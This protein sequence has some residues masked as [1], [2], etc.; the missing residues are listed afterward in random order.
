M[1]RHKNHKLL[2]EEPV[3]IDVGD[4]VV[5]L[6]PKEN[7][8]A[9]PR[10]KF[11]EC[12]RLME[13]PKDFDAVPGLILGYNQAERALFDKHLEQVV[14]KLAFGGRADILLPI[15][16]EPELNRFHL[17]RKMAREGMRGF[18]AQNAVDDKWEALKA[19][20]RARRYRAL[21]GRQEL[22]LQ[23]ASPLN[24]S[25]S[26]NSLAELTSATPPAG[27]SE[28]SL[29]KDPIVIGT[30]AGIC[31]STSIRYNSS[32]DHHSHTLR[33][34]KLLMSTSPTHSSS[35][36]SLL[37]FIITN[38][39]FPTKTPEMATRYFREALNNFKHHI[40]DIHLLT[41]SLKTVEQ[42]LTATHKHITDPSTRTIPGGLVE[43]VSLSIF[44]RQFDLDP[45][46]MKD[47]AKGYNEL[48]L[49][50]RKELPAMEQMVEKSTRLWE[51]ASM[52]IM[53]SPKEKV[54]GD[55]VCR[56]NLYLEATQ[57]FSKWVQEK[58]GEG[59]ETCGIGHKWLLGEKLEETEATI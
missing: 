7:V 53:Q 10:A 34:A 25:H 21:L 38:T 28:L 2:E 5:Q 54:I 23:Y 47:Q 22:Q 50:L 41:Q 58:K 29:A 43:P 35:P 31:A 19:L 14:R 8:P 6:Q 15:M 55:I 27:A 17:N 49:R 44:P 9:L 13:H 12:V 37:Q 33:Y 4:E 56:A 36:W 18:M 24:T 57:K 30:I 26:S 39:A 51:E 48:A 40:V 46:K 1:Y 42:V 11:T 52:D 3:Y 45:A 16:E 32:L 59:V 20:K